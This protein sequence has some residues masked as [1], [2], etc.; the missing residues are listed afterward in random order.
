MNLGELYRWCEV[1]SIIPAPDFIDEPFVVSFEFFMDLEDMAEVPGNYEEGDLFRVFVSSRRLLEFSSY[2][3]SVLQAD[4]TYKLTWQSFPIL[5]MGIKALKAL[6]F[7]KNKFIS[8]L[9]EEYE[10]NLCDKT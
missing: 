4:G 10:A 1:N 6:E 8:I 5:I 7:Q 3:K 2:T 9:D